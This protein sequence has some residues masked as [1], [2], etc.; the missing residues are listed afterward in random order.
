MSKAVLA[1][2]ICFLALPVIT[3]AQERAA[4]DPLAGCYRIEV[5]Q[6]EPAR[7]HSDNEAYQTP[8]EE[9]QLYERTG[10]A[11]FEQGRNIVRPVI[12]HGRD[13]SAFWH[14]TGSDSVQVVWTNGHSGVRLD[15]DASGDVLRGTATALIDV[16]GPPIPEA[17]V[18]VRR[19]P[20]ASSE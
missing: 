16:D 9:F 7:L 13:P 15:L 6:W 8:P 20:C 5:A 1:L 11:V 4:G 2:L 17:E 19:T 12:P 14:R 18:V 10:E 3:G